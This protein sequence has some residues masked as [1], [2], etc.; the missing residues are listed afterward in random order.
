MASA[1]GAAQAHEAAASPIAY[2]SPTRNKVLRKMHELEIRGGAR[3]GAPETRG[4]TREGAILR[5]RVRELFAN[6]YVCALRV[7]YVPVCTYVKGF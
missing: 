3:G 6:S 7:T 5:L 1:S 2:T 4:M